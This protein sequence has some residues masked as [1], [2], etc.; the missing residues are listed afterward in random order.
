M[1][2]CQQLVMAAFY[3]TASSTRFC[4]SVLSHRMLRLV[5]GWMLGWVL[6]GCW[7]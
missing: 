2:A 4:L 1:M 6:D 7:G 5:L 3:A